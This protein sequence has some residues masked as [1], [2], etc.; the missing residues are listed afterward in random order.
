MVT[1]RIFVTW[2]QEGPDPRD[3]HLAL[4]GFDRQGRQ[5]NLS[6]TVRSLIASNAI[7]HE[8]HFAIGTGKSDL[9]NFARFLT[10]PLRNAVYSP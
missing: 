7:W 6:D 10:E 4:E 8:I 9:S 2:E 3:L 5:G 1:G